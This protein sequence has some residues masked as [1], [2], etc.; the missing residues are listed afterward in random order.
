[1]S[2][3]LLSEEAVQS[4]LAH[5]ARGTHAAPSDDTPLIRTDVF[6]AGSGPIGPTYAHTI[7]DQDPN[8]TVL[9]ADIGVQEDVVIGAHQKN[10]VKFQKDIDSFGMYKAPWGALQATSVPMPASYL[11]TLP[12]VSWAPVDTDI[13][14]II[15]FNPKQQVSTDLPACAVTR[16]VGGMATHWTCACPEPHAEERKEN[17]INQRELDTLLQR[18]KA[19]LDVNGDQFDESIRHSVVKSTLADALKGTREVRSIPLAA[20]RRSENKKFVTWSGSNTTRVTRL[21]RDPAN[22]SRIVAAVCRNLKTDHDILVVAKVCR[23]DTIKYV[24]LTLLNVLLSSPVDRRIRPDVL[25]KNLTEQSIAFCQIVLKRSI[26]EAIST[27]PA[28]KDLVAEHREKH[29]NDPLLIPFDN[30]EPQ[31]TIP[32]SSE[33][34]WHTQIHRDAFSYGD[35]GPR[36]DPR[37]VVTFSDDHTDIHGLPQPTFC[38]KRS[39][40]DGERDHRIMQDMTSIANILGGYLPGSEPQFMEAAHPLSLRVP[41]VSAMTP[42]VADP[43]S[44]VH[45]LSNL[46]VGG[47]GC[48]P[49]STACN[50]PLTSVAIAIKGAEYLV[51]YLK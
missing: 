36:S 23:N 15:G 28:Y 25:G 21:A 29:P 27:N 14:V 17:P 20:R 24:T 45:G 35:V 19:L 48:I 34:P 22:P 50:P 12:V 47:N 16:T 42:R 6:I 49:D 9:M 33:H 32:Y 46:W 3:F 18:G 30:P 2:P 26:V 40:E 39:R 41:L 13:L 38:V 8:A 5:L 44:K 31:V 7:T 11:A 51:A 1:M 37:V 4:L 10:A 43:S